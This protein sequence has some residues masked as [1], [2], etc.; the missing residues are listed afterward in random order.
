MARG[1]EKMAV[2]AAGIGERWQEQ[3]LL[4]VWFVFDILGFMLTIGV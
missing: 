4:A 2:N 1:I 3:E